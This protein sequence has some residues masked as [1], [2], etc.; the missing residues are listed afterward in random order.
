MTL[1]ALAA[2]DRSSVGLVPRSRACWTGRLAPGRGNDGLGIRRGQHD[3]RAPPVQPLRGPLAGREHEH[4]GC[5]QG[6]RGSAKARLLLC[7][8]RGHR[9]GRPADAACHIDT[10]RLF[11]VASLFEGGPIGQANRARGGHRRHNRFPGRLC[12]R[13]SAAL[14]ARSIWGRG[15]PA[16]LGAV[17]MAVGSRRARFAGEIGATPLHMGPPL[18][19]A[20]VVLVRLVRNPN[21]HGA[22]PLRSSASVLGRLGLGISACSRSPPLF[23]F[24]LKGACHASNRLGGLKGCT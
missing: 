21:S 12:L 1:A 17:R 18:P 22:G 24:Y 23:H 7:G 11:P 16:G 6:K 13:A 10:F 15:H 8:R 5:G 19:A 9:K 4:T 14:R 20:H 3:L 2:A